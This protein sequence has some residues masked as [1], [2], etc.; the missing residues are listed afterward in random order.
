MTGRLFRR[1]SL[2]TWSLGALAMGLLLGVIG[3]ASGLPAFGKLA[4]AVKP[5]GDVWLAAL[6][7]IVLPLV[8]AS[9][10]S[11]IVGARG[12]ES[13]A[14]LGARALILFLVM[15]VVAGL[16]TL[17]LAPPI[18]SA[19]RVDR[20]TV[21]S[22]QPATPA[23]ETARRSGGAASLSQ[24]IA[25]LLPRNLTEAALGGNILPILLFTILFAIAV[26]RLPD[27]ERLPL[28]RAFHAIAKAMLLCV[29]WVLWVTPVGVFALSYV[30]ALK[31]GTEAVG[32]LGIFVLIMSGLLLLFTVLLYPVSVV[33]GRTTF[34]AFARAAAPAQL[35][36]VS[37]RSSIASLPALVEGGR[38]HL[39]LPDSSTSFVI[40]LAVS[41]FKVNRTVSSTVK[42]LFL[43][44][45]YGIVLQPGAIATFLATVILLSFS[46]AGVPSSGSLFTIPAYL[47]AGVPIEG[48]MILDAAVTI[49]DVFRTLLNVTGDMSV[50]TLLSRSSRAQR[51]DVASQTDAPASPDAEPGRSE[52]RAPGR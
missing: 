6:Q 36:A 17:V 33:L 8:I 28:A 24:W 29:R 32:M 35:V 41:V 44:H 37:T 48:V 20:A 49:P 13:V 12:K 5:I 3:R 45:I 25:G 18:I 39:K 43:A 46:T 21:E 27:E 34:R 31:T 38:E 51:G 1:A 52:I 42:L 19:Y 40:P 30:L 7:M 11:S 23:P 16:V 10:L 4:V 50:A 9:V 14:A 22:L 15:L 47:A 2:T 26:T